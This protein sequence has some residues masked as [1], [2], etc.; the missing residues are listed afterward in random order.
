MDKS[1]YSPDIFEAIVRC[2]RKNQQSW[3]RFPRFVFSCGAAPSQLHPAR[4]DLRWHI[5]NRREHDKQNAYC[6]SAEAVVESNVFDGADLITQEAMI[7]DVADLIIVFA[8]SIGAYCELGAFTALPH[9]LEI[10]SVAVD[11]NERGRD[12]YLMLGPARA[13]KDHK[14]PLCEVFY[15]DFNCVLANE[16]LVTFVDSLHSIINAADRLHGRNYRRK[17]PNEDVSSLSVGPLVHELIDVLNILEPITREDLL[18]AYLLVK[19]FDPEGLRIYSKTIS[20]DLSKDAEIS[21]DQVI[22][23]MKANRLIVEERVSS[24]LK[25]L[26]SRIRPRASFLFRATNE[27]ELNEVR[28]RVLLRKRERSMYGVKRVYR[29]FDER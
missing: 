6:L 8:E 10:T 15:V 3:S 16:T 17:E 18:E 29:P 20:E 24:Q 21:Y 7:V 14:S 19:E 2:K 25:V 28:A 13:V 9:A 1:I 23:F 22:E 5:D 11:K 26:R 4:A 27:K 12:S